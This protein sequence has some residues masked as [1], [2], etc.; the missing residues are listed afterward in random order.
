[1]K[2]HEIPILVVFISRWRDQENTGNLSPAA[3][4]S[5]TVQLLKQ[6]ATTAEDHV[7]SSL[8]WDAAKSAQVKR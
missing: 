8:C 6:S 2:Y 3:F 5:V 7:V 1:M 4:E